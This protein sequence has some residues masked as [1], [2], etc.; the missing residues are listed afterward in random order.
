VLGL[1]ET[2]SRT[3][4]ASQTRLPGGQQNRSTIPLIR[5]P[6]DLVAAALPYPGEAGSLFSRPA[7]AKAAGRFPACKEVNS[8]LHN[9]HIVFCPLQA[10]QNEKKVHNVEKGE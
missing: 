7:P 2:T 3:P 10:G 1:R 9:Q 8:T 5:S 6:P 4:S